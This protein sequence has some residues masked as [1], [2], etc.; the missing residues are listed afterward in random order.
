MC[1]KSPTTPFIACVGSCS[2]FFSTSNQR[3]SFKA[4]ID[5]NKLE[6]KKGTRNLKKAEHHEVSVRDGVFFEPEPKHGGSFPAQEAGL[7]RVLVRHRCPR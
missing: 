1:P 5:N 7:R 3:L 4:N 2:V 6:R